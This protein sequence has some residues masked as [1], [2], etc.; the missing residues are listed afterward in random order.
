MNG[1]LYVD[2]DNNF[3]AGCGWRMCFNQN[4][5]YDKNNNRLLLGDYDKSDKTFKIFGNL[6]VQLTANKLLKSI[7]CPNS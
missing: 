5:I 6:Y 3:L 7:A 1:I 4:I 2:S